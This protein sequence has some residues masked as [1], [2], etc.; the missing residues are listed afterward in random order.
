[1]PQSNFQPFL[2]KTLS[3]ST[4]PCWA[5]ST[6]SSAMLP[7]RCCCRAALKWKQMIWH[8]GLL[9]SSCLSKLPLHVCDPRTS[10]TG[11]SLIHLC[12]KQ[13]TEIMILVLLRSSDKSKATVTCLYFTHLDIIYRILMDI[14]VHQNSLFDNQLVF[15]DLSTT[16]MNCFFTSV[17]AH[18]YVWYPRG[19][20][21]ALRGSYRGNETSSLRIWQDVQLDSQWSWALLS[22]LFLYL[23]WVCNRSGNLVMEKGSISTVLFLAL[24]I[25][26][27]RFYSSSFRGR[28]LLWVGSLLA[29]I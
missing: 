14:N 5:A 26:L 29:W 25:N 1:M 23:T 27:S 10:G 21:W 19:T 3:F 18:V 16:C 12:K 22:T 7:K 15:C 20:L 11:V 13:S 6:N 24:I 17:F 2:K 8:P 9:S 4:F 28:S